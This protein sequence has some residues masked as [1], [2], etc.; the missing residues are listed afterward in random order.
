MLKIKCMETV[1]ASYSK[2]P[3]QRYE[4]SCPFCSVT[5]TFFYHSP[6]ICQSCFMDLPE[7][8]ELFNSEEFKKL[9]HRG[10]T[11]IKENKI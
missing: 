4:Y 1:A 7:V 2:L 11:T 8:G 5:I 10:K 9:W 3:A 6:K